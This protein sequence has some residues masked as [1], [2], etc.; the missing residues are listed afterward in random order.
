M[1]YYFCLLQI[2]RNPNL[3]FNA[4]INTLKEV[5]NAGNEALVNEAIVLDTLL[6]RNV[7]L[8]FRYQGSL[9]TPPC[10]ESVTWILFPDPNDISLK[11][12]RIY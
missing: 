7:D 8:F 1:S 5:N 9:T 6:P 10:Y 4:L 3:N 12:V 11:Q 2:T